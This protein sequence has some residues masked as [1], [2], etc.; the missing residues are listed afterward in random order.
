MTQEKNVRRTALR[1]ALRQTLPILTGF[2]FIGLGYGVYMNVLGFSF[3]YPLCM[4]ALIFG[5]SLEF[6]AATLLLSPF[7]PVQAFLLALMIQARHIFY[8]LSTCDKYGGTGWKKPYLIFGMC[9]ES[10]AINYTTKLPPGIDAAWFM[11]FVTLLN[12]IYWVAG[13]TLGGVFGGSLPFNTDGI[14]FVMTAMFVV[15]FIEQWMNDRQHY[16]GVLGLG[17]AALCLT[18][19]GRDGF[20][21]PTMLVILA[22]CLLA[23]PFLER[24]AAG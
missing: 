13:A 11:F 18:A 21:I 3:W 4:S 5:G 7:A 22:A 24:R 15:I 6:I 20:M 9:D 23:R 17:T 19:F 8:G 14:E 12:Q 1:F 10:F 16:T 2:L